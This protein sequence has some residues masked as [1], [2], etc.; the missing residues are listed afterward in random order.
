MASRRLA[1]GVVGNAG[2]AVP[3]V[4]A[5]AEADS[6]AVSTEISV[7]VS[8]GNVAARG[9]GR[10]VVSNCSWYLVGVTHSDHNKVSVGEE[11]VTGGAMES[12]DVVATVEA[13]DAEVS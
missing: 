7:E 11:T 2:I 1:G 9:E 6:V 4:I 8:E 13:V 12:G 5:E 10:E 3:G